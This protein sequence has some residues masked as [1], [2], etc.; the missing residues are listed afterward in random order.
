MKTASW[1]F[2][3]AVLVVGFLTPALSA[4]TTYPTATVTASA[5]VYPQPEASGT[6]VYSLE[7]GTVVQVMTSKGD[8][9][10]IIFED[11]RAGRRVGFVQRGRVVVSAPLTDLPKSPL[12]PP[13]PT[14]P[15]TEPAIAK[16]SPGRSMYIRPVEAHPETRMDMVERLEKWGRWPLVEDEGRADVVLKLE[17]SGSGGLGRATVVA[18]IIDPATGLALW[19]S[20]KQTGSRTVFRGY[21]SSSARANDGIVEQMKEAAKQWPSQSKAPSPVAHE[22]NS[23]HSYKFGLLDDPCGTLDV[24]K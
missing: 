13:P 14:A 15:T 16:L 12:P 11:K 10:E 5:P 21:S 22:E 4:Q 24:T 20:K 2:L 9:L 7:A 6:P 17:T 19:R 23:C 18:T 1:R 8:W 3:S